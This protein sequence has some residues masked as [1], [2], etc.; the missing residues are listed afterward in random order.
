MSPYSWVPSNAASRMIS[1]ERDA[2]LVASVIVLPASELMV[3]AMSPARSSASSAAPEQD[4]H[5]RVR[6]SATPP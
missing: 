4:L 2:S 1:P 3:R 5:P 6:R